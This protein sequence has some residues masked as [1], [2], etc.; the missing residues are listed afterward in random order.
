MA[1]IAIFR[2]EG[3]KIVE[4]WGRVDRLGMCRQPGIHLLEAVHQVAD[5]RVVHGLKY[6][7]PYSAI[8]V[9]HTQLGEQKDVLLQILAHS[10][11][12][13]RDEVIEHL[14]AKIA[15]LSA[16]VGLL[17]AEANIDKAHKV[18]DLPA[19]PLRKRA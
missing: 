19:L 13:I 14:E 11:A 9:D 3:S 16:E 10:L 1:E 4:K 2:M 5:K 8:V 6:R 12:R 17:R 15:E 18:V 7:P